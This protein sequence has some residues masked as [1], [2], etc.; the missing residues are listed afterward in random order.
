MSNNP[1]CPVFGCTIP[2]GI[3]HEHPAGVSVVM[4]DPAG[5]LDA[6]ER[7]ELER[8]RAEDEQDRRT[9]FVRSNLNSK[10]Y[11]SLEDMHARYAEPGSLRDEAMHRNNV[12]VVP[13]DAP[14]V[15][16]RK[17]RDALLMAGQNMQQPDE[18]MIVAADEALR[19]E[20]NEAAYVDGMRFE[21]K[22]GTPNTGDPITPDEIE[23]RISELALAGADWERPKCPPLVRTAGRFMAWIFGAIGVIA[24]L[25]LSAMTAGWL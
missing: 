25:I 8:Y 23:Q 7:A 15:P 5:P 14:M 24:I 13:A 22:S 17:L 2:R 1:K 16:G 4:R 10:P 9:V 6:F 18:V 20:M 19:M 12:Y 3:P 11:I 21:F